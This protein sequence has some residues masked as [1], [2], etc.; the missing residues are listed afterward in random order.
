MNWYNKYIVIKREDIKNYLQGSDANMLTYLAG[1]V[2]RCREGDGRKHNKYVV[3]N[4]D[5]HYA[6]IVERIIELGEEFNAMKLGSK[7]ESN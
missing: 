4:T 5:E 7:D 3:V 6:D 2:D 1:K